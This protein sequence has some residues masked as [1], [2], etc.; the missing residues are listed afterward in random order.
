ML[1]PGRLRIDTAG[2]AERWAMIS[3]AL[4]RL[5]S[6]KNF[7]GM[8]MSPAVSTAKSSEESF[9]AMIPLSIG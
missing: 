1:S 3:S 2:T 8:E 5:V 4:R 9:S 7:L 6:F